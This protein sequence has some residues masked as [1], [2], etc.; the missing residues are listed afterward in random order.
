MILAALVWLTPD[1][2]EA[3]DGEAYLAAAYV[4]MTGG[5]ITS[6]VY[7]HIALM[8]G[9]ADKTLGYTTMGLAGANALFGIIM[10]GVSAAVDSSD[11]P[12]F[13]GFG[14]AHLSLGVVGA[15]S[16]GT[17]VANTPAPPGTIAP[18]SDTASITIPF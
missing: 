12:L 8:E 18:A 6:T 3:H 15:I 13:V 14:V 1:R 11:R 5:G 16:G 10:V 4:C 2:A 7:S 9:E 17:V